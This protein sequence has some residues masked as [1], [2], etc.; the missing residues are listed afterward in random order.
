[1]SNLKW[2]FFDMGSTLIDETEAYNHRVRDMLT[3]TDISFETFDQMR[4]SLARQG[5]DGNS[6]AIKQLGLE[7]TPW[8]VEDEVLFSD[9]GETLKAL[10]QKRYHL[11]IIAN[12]APG[13]E[14]RLAAWGVL[15]YFDRVIASSEVGLAKPDRAIFQ[16]ALKLAACKADES[17]MVGDRLDNDIAPAKAIG[18]KTVWL[19]RG[20]SQYQSAN[21]GHG[22]ADYQIDTLSALLNIL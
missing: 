10:C 3:G 1:M 11:G 7:K 15:K 21:L 9:V 5:Y 8:H 14:K 16:K 13:S 19:K 4:I 22:I 6:E 17:M 12:Q 18:M 20:L 2:I